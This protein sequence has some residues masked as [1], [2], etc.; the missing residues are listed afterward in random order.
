MDQ[1]GELAADTR[2][3]SPAAVTPATATCT[4]SVFQGD[5]EKRHAADDRASSRPAWTWAGRSRPS[6]ASAPAKLPYLME[7]EDPAKVALMRRI[8]EAFDPNGILNPGKVFDRHST[9]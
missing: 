3:G 5:A 6:T 2:R 9:R 1:V 4:S 8:K 7:L